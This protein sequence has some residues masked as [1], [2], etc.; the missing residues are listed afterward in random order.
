MNRN[1]DVIIGESLNGTI[2]SWSSGAER[3]YGYGSG[4]AVGSSIDLIVPPERRA[5]LR[6]ILN[7]VGR[8]EEVVRLETQRIGSDGARMDVVVSLWPVRDQS[9]AIVGACSL[10]TD[11]GA[12]DIERELEELERRND[13]LTAAATLAEAATRARPSRPDEP[14]AAHAVELGAR[15]RPAPADGRRSRRRAS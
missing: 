7:R 9:E 15:F 8:G 11:A 2:V 14:R 10:T 1:A 12:T 5:E 3:L 4:D 13:E 6:W